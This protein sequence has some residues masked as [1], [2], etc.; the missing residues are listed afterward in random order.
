M[1]GAFVIALCVTGCFSDRGVA[2]EVDVGETGATSVELYIGKEACVDNRPAG[3]GCS[4]IL[5]PGAPATQGNDNVWFRDDSSRYM[6]D[7]KGRTATFQLKADKAIKIPF[8][9][10]VGSD[11][12]MHPVGTA[13]LSDLEIPINTARIVT[14]TLIN[15]NPVLPRPT[16][17]KN[18]TDDRVMVWDKASSP[19]S[20]SSCVVVEHW[21]RGQPVQRDFV[22]PFE[23]LDC[24]GFP[25]T[26]DCNANASGSTPGGLAP[27][28]NC[29]GAD[30]SGACL[31]GSLGCAD[32]G[33]TV[34]GTCAPQNLQHDQEA[35]C[36]P[37][38]FCAPS[39]TNLD[40]KCPQGLIDDGSSQVPRIECHIPR[41]VEGN[42]CVG[43]SSAPINLDM[44]YPLSQKCDQLQLGAF[45]FT[46]LSTNS[47]TH[48]F[49][50][51]VMDLSSLKTPCNF[52]ITWKSG[53]RNPL[54]MMA[55]HGMIQ[56]QSGDRVALLPLVLR[57]EPPAT[58]ALGQFKC[59]FA[60]NMSDSLWAC[61][62][63]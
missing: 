36:V 8:I 54:D 31:L 5:P 9:V 42:L 30:T 16:D 57:F 19:S 56:L 23:D 34:S 37:S 35:V 59:T 43:D 17:P 13:R 26:N 48:T 53:T 6:A 15:A 63:P 60:G 27:Q 44:F 28:P 20:P 29:F 2:I 25:N 39:C 7:V 50:G 58:C 41:S 10:A 3:A 33:G 40:P 32:S 22:V 51:A 62:R 45:Q 24:D 52:A 38:Q 4:T 55:D 21:E 18:T 14:T 11:K 49:G 1:R 47:T 12:P 46:T 61:A